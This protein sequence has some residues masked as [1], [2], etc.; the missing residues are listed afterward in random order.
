MTGYPIN[1][2]LLRPLANNRNSGIDGN[3]V[4]YRLTVFT[5]LGLL[6]LFQI[7]LLSLI[8]V[9]PALGINWRLE[10][11]PGDPGLEVILYE[12]YFY[13]SCT[14]Y[15]G[16]CA[17]TV[18]GEDTPEPE[19]NV[20]ASSFCEYGATVTTGAGFPKQGTI[21]AHVSWPSSGAINEWGQVVRFWVHLVYYDA[22]HIYNFAIE[23]K[24]VDADGYIYEYQASIEQV[25]NNASL[26][27]ALPTQM[28][29][30]DTQR[31][32]I[33]A[34][35]TGSS[36]WTDLLWISLGAV[37]DSDPFTNQTRINLPGSVGPDDTCVF[38]ID[39]TAPLTP[40]IYRTDWQMIQ[41]YYQRF[42]NIIS[43]DIEVVPKP[44]PIAYHF[45]SDSENWTP[46][47]VPGFSAPDF[48]WD[49]GLVKMISS[50]N[51]NTFGYW[52]SPE[53]AIP[54]DPDYLYRA[55]FAVSTSVTD[56]PL[57]P[58]IRLRSN[59]LNLQQYDVLSI[60]SAGDGG[61]C[62]ESYP[63]LTD[64]DL[65][66]VPPANDT[67][68]MLGFD[69]CNFDPE[70]AA[71]AEIAL[72]SVIV[73][74]FA[75]SSLAAPTVVQDYTFELSE[76]GWTTGGAPIVYSPPQYIYSSGA[77]ELR[78]TTN[79]NTFGFWVNDPGD[80][81]IETDRLYRGTFEVR[82]DFASPALVPE[83]RLRFNTGNAQASRMLG[84]VSAGDGAN[85][86]GTTNTTYDQLYFSP[87]WNCVGE[88]LIVSFDILNFN[89]NDAAEASLILDRA[90][91]EMLSPPSFP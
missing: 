79:T 29:A 49:P 18:V 43:Q 38:E 70:D 62:P 35:N 91:I 7:L 58:Q 1:G 83:M 26:S 33:T 61:A 57:V 75:L 56:K 48:V 68:T 85:S 5:R 39:L 69:L 77:L 41:E 71:D 89:P 2:A 54:A 34:R 45:M 80:I 46:I 15:L 16:S 82:R 21:L 44:W 9:T 67:A 25:Y 76:D 42:G 81:T 73:D 87:P 37:G 12:S 4:K 14:F 59:S 60:E 6:R 30:G 86:P 55:R 22:A 47:S 90:V 52:L 28:Y 78:A 13:S 3:P 63:T 32:V 53:D 51:T 36:Y 66:F 20:F 50:T 11:H 88:A 27:T 40:G 10:E 31:V 24:T 84:I 64:Y 19:Y 23:P 17:V 8:S 74:R 72:I 65:Y